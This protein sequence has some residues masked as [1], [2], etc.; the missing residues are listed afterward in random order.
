LLKKN[1]F[2]SSSEMNFGEDFETLKLRLDGI[3]QIPSSHS[4]TSI[5]L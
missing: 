3:L 1:K 5:I 4:M 2:K